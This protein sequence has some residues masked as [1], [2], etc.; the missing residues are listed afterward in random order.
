M[1]ELNLVSHRLK[2]RLIQFTDLEA[3]HELHSLPEVDHFNTL[4]IP[5][6]MAITSKIISPQI[7]AH[8][9]DEIL[10]Y[11]F[12]IEE[13]ET[14]L[15]IGLFGLNLGSKKYNNA[16]IWYKLNPTH[17]NKGYAT[18]AVKCVLRFCF[19]TLKLHRVS[20]GCAIENIGSIRV[21]E[22]AGMTREGHARKTLPLKTG[23]SDNYEYA[24]LETDKRT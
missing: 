2:L 24:I 8:D 9:Q 12:A 4:G 13:L 5:E 1:K 18:E 22:K 7:E 14:G 17:W 21:L 20:A 10:S 16:E 23:W 3:M 15:F 6:S 11:T 19:E